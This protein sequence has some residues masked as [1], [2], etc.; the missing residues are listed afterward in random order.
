MFTFFIT[1]SQKCM[2]HIFWATRALV[3]ASFDYYMDNVKVL[4]PASHTSM[5][6]KPPICGRTTLAGTM[7]FGIKWLQICRSLEAWSG[8]RW[9]PC[10]VRVFRQHL[11]PCCLKLNTRWE[12]LSTSGIARRSL[13]FR[14]LYGRDET[15]G[16]HASF[17]GNPYEWTVLVL[18]H[19]V[20][21]LA[22]WKHISTYTYQG[23]RTVQ[24]PKPFLL[25]LYKM[26][27]NK[28]KY[29]RVFYGVV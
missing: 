23:L 15:F 22:D 21:G 6:K 7:I 26:Q 13:C 25:C 9:M 27:I 11:L 8:M 4:K 14:G 20:Q 29:S 18:K 3:S 1:G 24:K 28:T 5:I 2:K 17:W 16:R 12:K 19:H 10:I